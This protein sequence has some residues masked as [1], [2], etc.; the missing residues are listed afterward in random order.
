MPRTKNYIDVKG[1]RPPVDERDPT[2]KRVVPEVIVIEDSDTEESEAGPVPA[3]DGGMST[4]SVSSL[5][6]AIPQHFLTPL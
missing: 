5:L 3:L 2:T 1:W 4:P 6:L